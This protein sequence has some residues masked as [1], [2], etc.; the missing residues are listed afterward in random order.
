[1]DNSASLW[2]VVKGKGTRTMTVYLKP[3]FRV[4]SSQERVYHTEKCQHYRKGNPEVF[5]EIPKS[6]VPD[7]VR[8]CKACAGT[9]NKNTSP[10]EALADRLEREDFKPE[11]LGL[12]PMGER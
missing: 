3:S 6:E 10:R 4:N 5:K 7:N 9:A 11:D 1:M 12:S 2:H 8:R